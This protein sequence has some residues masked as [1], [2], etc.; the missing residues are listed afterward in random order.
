MKVV[1]ATWVNIL[2]HPLADDEHRVTWTK[3]DHP[4]DA[5]IDLRFRPFEIKTLKLDIA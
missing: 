2:E 3:G 5:V 1:E 4:G